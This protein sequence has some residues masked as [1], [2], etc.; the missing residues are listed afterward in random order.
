MHTMATELQ[1]TRSAAVLLLALGENEASTVLKQ[2]D[3]KVV[4]RLGSAMAQL[5]SASRE[6]V[7]DV[8]GDF[9]Q[10]MEGQA[11]SRFG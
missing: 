5:K 2:L 9:V 4:Q 7:S 6:E 1:S 8:V 11:D 3:A 10:T